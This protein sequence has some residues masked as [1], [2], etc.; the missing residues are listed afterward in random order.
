MLAQYIYFH[1]SSY[2]YYISQ[3]VARDVVNSVRSNVV[4]VMKEVHEIRQ[5]RDSDSQRTKEFAD[6]ASENI[7]DTFERGEIR[8]TTGN[9][10]MR[11]NYF[12]KLHFN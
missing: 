9:K 1:A 11:T 10:K 8:H 12:F 3:D 5:F 7:S 4:N 2:V 6:A